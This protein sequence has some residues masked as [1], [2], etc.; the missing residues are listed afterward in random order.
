M[1]LTAWDQVMVLLGPASGI[2]VHQNRCNGPIQEAIEEKPVVLLRP[3]LERTVSTVQGED[4]GSFEG[5]QESFRSWK[6]NTVGSKL[7]RDRC[8]VP[9]LT[10]TL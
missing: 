9:P 1:G 3:G 4:S 10:E 7:L 8:G 2:C 6:I 5:R